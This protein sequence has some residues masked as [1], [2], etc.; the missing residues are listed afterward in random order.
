VGIA[1]WRGGSRAVVMR[2]LIAAIG[3][4]KAASPEHQLFID[5]TKRLPWKLTLREF[6]VR[7][8]SPEQR[9]QREAAQLLEA[10]AGYECIVA[11]DE[12]G[13]TLSSREFSDF[14]KTRQQRGESSMA[15]VIGGADGL[16]DTLRKKADMLWSFGRVTWPH[17]LVRPM[18]A[19]QLYRAHTLITGHPY[20]RD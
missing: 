3:K 14:I 12:A 2:V 4:A 11:L 16:H 18:L 6:D 15:L 19:E 8:S 7:E 13:K 10:C 5:Y 1:P 9:K 17:M 20:H